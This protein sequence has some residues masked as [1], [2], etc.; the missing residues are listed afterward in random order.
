MQFPLGKKFKTWKIG[1]TNFITIGANY[2]LHR[3]ELVYG[4][5]LQ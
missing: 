4:K 3:I 1:S 5:T 2:V